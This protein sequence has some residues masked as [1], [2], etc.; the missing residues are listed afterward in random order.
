MTLV[1][2]MSLIIDGYNLLHVTG[3]TSRRGDLQG[4]RAAL[5][6]FLAAVIEPSERPRTTIVFDAAEAPAGLPRTVVIDDMTVRYASDYADADEL[7]E[8]LIGESRVPRS[9]LVVSSDHRVQ[10]A[11]RRRRAQFVDSEV[12]FAEAVRRREQLRRPLLPPTTVKPAAPLSSHEI[13]YWV[14]E[15][16]GSIADAEGATRAAEEEDASRNAAHPP[17]ENDL[18]EDLRNPFPPGYADDMLNDP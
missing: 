12:W 7:I 6:R 13:N 4:S 5:L 1:R 2:S 18:P 17:D 11:A 14:A 8:E 15:F 16:S 3:I 9:L 10:R